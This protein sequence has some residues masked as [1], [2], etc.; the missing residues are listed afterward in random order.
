MKF[1]VFCCNLGPSFD[2]FSIEVNHGGFFCAMGRSRTYLDRKV[3]LFDELSWWSFSCYHLD[4][5]L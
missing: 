2:R 4:Y 5:I 3:D 1:M